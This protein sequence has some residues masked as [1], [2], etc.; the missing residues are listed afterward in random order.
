MELAPPR[1]STSYS[2]LFEPNQAE[3]LDVPSSTPPRHFAIAFHLVPRHRLS[4]T[5][6]LSSHCRTGKARLGL[7][8]A[9]C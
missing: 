4:T 8:A 6:H 9:C 1:R 5:G 3:V 2:T 7:C